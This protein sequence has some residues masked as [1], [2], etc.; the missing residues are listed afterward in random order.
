[1]RDVMMTAR[2]Q[3]I[4]DRSEINQLVKDT[5]TEVDTQIQNT[6]GAAGYEEYQQ[7]EKT[8]PQRNV[9]NQLSQ[10]LSYTSTPLNDSQTQ[11]LIQVLA[12]NSSGTSSD[13]PRQLLGFG[14]GPGGYGGSVPITDAAIAQAQSVLAPSQLQAL[15]A[16][17]QQQQAQEELRKAAR[18]AQQNTASQTTPA[19]PTSTTPAK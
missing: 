8:L 13:S 18:A 6:L 4:T 12:N 15:T 2:S 7:Y 3:G 10:S 9:V 14:G 11:Q 16:L 17:Q 1:M 19:A 5:Q